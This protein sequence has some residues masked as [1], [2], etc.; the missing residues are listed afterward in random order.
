M[1][2]TVFFNSKKKIFKML[3]DSHYYIFTCPVLFEPFK[4]HIKH[5][6]HILWNAFVCYMIYDSSKK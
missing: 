2:V 1:F 6:V 5:V 3:T 4:F